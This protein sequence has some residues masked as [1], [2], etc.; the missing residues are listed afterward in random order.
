MQRLYRILRNNYILLLSLFIIIIYRLFYF[1]FG[2]YTILYNSDTVTYFTKNNLLNLK[3]DLYRT[4]IYPFILNF[5]EYI[6]L[7][8]FIRN[9]IIFQHLIAIICLLFL[10]ISIQNST[11]NK[12][13]AAITTVIFGCN[14]LVLD[15]IKNINPESIAIAGSILSLFIISTYIKNPTKWKAIILG[16]FPFVL[17][18]LKPNFLIL[19]AILFLFIF[20]RYVFKK[21]ERSIISHAAYSWIFSIICLIGYCYLNKK[22]N[23]EF[24]LSKISLNNS[25]SNIAKSGA[26]K[27]G[28]DRE[29]IAIVDKTKNKGYYKYY[30]TVFTINNEF[31][32]KFK[33]HNQTKILKK[34]PP[35][36]DIEFCL[37]IP[38]TIN[39]STDRISKF[40]NY[41][42]KTKTFFTFV[43][44]RL[45]DIII[46]K[47]VLFCII[48]IQLIYNI[49]IIR[50][51]KKIEWISFVVI[52]LILS[53]YLTIAINGINDWERLLL[54]SY[55]LIAF[56][57]AYFGFTLK[58][59]LINFNSN[60][61]SI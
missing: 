13:L 55:P 35:T 57:Y 23:N 4:P 56:V 14:H 39:Y 8:H 36:G 47:P 17:I 15:Q 54:P 40:I 24:T 1:K 32:D 18:M 21:E 46:Y 16:F 48:L 29:L 34:Y 44:K 52:S 12:Y 10:F 43:F 6:S 58:K 37:K 7:V 59:S 26:Y 19:I 49:L 5:F 28:R 22:I 27:L 41:S 30:T 38:D 42:Q 25:I 31:I 9:L 61:K 20:I 3:I 2:I 51:R 50:K 45:I 33:L 53:Q 11:K 60:L